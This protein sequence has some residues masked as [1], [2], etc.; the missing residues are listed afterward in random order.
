MTF[1]K[2]LTS[3]VPGKKHY[4]RNDFH[5]HSETYLGGPLVTHNFLGC[6]QT[7]ENL[8]PSAAV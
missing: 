3:S 1:E 7:G 8:T 2:F 5:K 6:L 4:F